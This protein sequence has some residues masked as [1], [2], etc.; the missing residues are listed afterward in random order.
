MPLPFNAFD[1]LGG[2]LPGMELCADWREPGP[3][4]K[5]QNSPSS[6]IAASTRETSIIGVPGVTSKVGNL[7]LL[8]CSLGLEL[9]GLRWASAVKTFVRREQ[10]KSDNRQASAS[11][12]S[13]VDLP[14]MI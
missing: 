4:S 14:D 3:I 12:T 7:R 13:S 10:V 8:V 2:R 5:H 11:S 1:C 9:A 6:S